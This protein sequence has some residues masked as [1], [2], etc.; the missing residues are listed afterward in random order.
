MGEQRHDHG[1]LPSLQHSDKEAMGRDVRYH[2]TVRVTLIGAIVD[3]SLGIT[4][5]MM[6]LFAHSQALVA[7]GIHSLSDLATDI[8]VLYAA[9]HASREADEEH[10]YGHGRME[11]VAT[12]A[13]GVSLIVIGLV[14]SGDAIR[15]LMYPDMLLHPGAWALAIAAVS[16]V[17][18]EAI[19][20]Y[21]MRIA[22]KHRSDMLHANAWHSRS[23][24][25]SSI[26]VLIGIAGTMV[27]AGYLDAVAAIAVGLMVARIGW[28]LSWK[29]VR[30]LVDT[31]LEKHQID[32]ICQTIMATDGVVAMHML[33]TRK[34]GGVALIDVHV[35]VN[36][37]IS[38]S[39]GH[40]I[41]DAVRRNLIETVPDVCDVT[42][43]IDPEDDMVATAT[44]LL[45]L[46][47]EIE[48]HLWEQFKGIKEAQHIE[49]LALHY[50]GGK[51]RVDI[52]FPLKLLPNDI[53]QQALSDQFRA[54]IEKDK[55]VDKLDVYFHSAS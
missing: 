6:G 32:T 37:N 1:H 26:I 5:I 39:E 44:A 35:Q 15:R 48:A 3:V 53:D 38:V 55:Q 33:R 34:M 20:H 36:S 18:K 14:I 12:V 17:S 30:E 9:K 43:H 23:D 28:N 21:T 47:K 54:A 8:L 45:P 19:Y 40:H 24:A 52:V 11:T 13:L 10:P 16:I 4:K 29:S 2:D 7:D 51:V 42:V 41:G 25:I 50:V 27:G 46:R 49:N 31:G 22:R